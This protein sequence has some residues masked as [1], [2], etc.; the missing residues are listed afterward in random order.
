MSLSF[1]QKLVQLL[2][3]DIKSERGA[4]SLDLLGFWPVSVL[5]FDNSV[6]IMVAF[7]WIMELYTGSMLASVASLAWSVWKLAVSAACSSFI[8]F[9]S[10]DGVA[11]GD[12]GTGVADDDAMGESGTGVSM[13]SL[14]FSCALKRSCS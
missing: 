9:S 2:I 8:E 4:C 10:T 3:G 13:V 5:I 7:S 11:I 12:S 6:I 14:R 1:S